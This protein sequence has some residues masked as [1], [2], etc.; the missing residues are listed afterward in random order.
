[1]ARESEALL[2]QNRQKVDENNDLS[3]KANK[4]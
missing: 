4:M 2:E 3:R 1:M